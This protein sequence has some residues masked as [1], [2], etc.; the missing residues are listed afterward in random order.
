MVYSLVVQSSILELFFALSFFK[1]I[2]GNLKICNVS[3]MGMC[4]RA[5]GQS[6]HN[7]ADCVLSSRGSYRCRCKPRFYGNGFTCKGDAFLILRNICFFL[8]PSFIFLFLTLAKGECYMAYGVMCHRNA[9]CAKGPA[10]RYGCRCAIGY[11]GDGFYC[12][13]KN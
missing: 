3:G 4:K 12:Q 7:D 10:G 2:S 1:Y 8:F 13:G 9:K 5:F 11:Y 6:C